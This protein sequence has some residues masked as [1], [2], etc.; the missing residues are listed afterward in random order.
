LLQASQWFNAKMTLIMI[1]DEKVLSAALA[2]LI[3]FDTR[4]A[5]IAAKVSRLPLR[6]AEPGFAALAR[7]IVSQQVS[8]VAAEKIYFRLEGAVGQMTPETYLAAGPDKWRE[9]GLSRP[10]QKTIAAAAQ[11]AINGT[12]DLDA[13]CGQD[14]ETAIET[15]TAIWGIG[16]WTAEVYLLFAGGHPDVFPARD[17]ALQ[18]ALQECFGLETRPTEAETIA[19]TQAWSPYRSVAARLM[20][21][22]YGFNRNIAA[23]LPA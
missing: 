18:I 20:W 23:P 17:L 6:H 5:P 19:F 3:A 16:R 11:A 9:G 13:L 2:E 8:A 22:I 10:K 7:V 12:L 15:M 4:L 21:A 14:A 1:R